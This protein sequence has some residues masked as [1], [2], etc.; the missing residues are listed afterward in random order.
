MLLKANCCRTRDN[1]RAIDF[2]HH[3]FTIARD[4]LEPLAPVS[5]KGGESITWC[6]V[7]GPS[8][9]WTCHL[10]QFSIFMTNESSSCKSHIVT[11]SAIVFLCSEANM[12]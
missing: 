5:E 1:K 3:R 6:V 10:P 8:N 12:F 9:W 7:L 11:D 2:G 4:Q